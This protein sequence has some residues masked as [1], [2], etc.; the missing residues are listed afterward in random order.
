M[1][2]DELQKLVSTLKSEIDRAALIAQLQALI[3]AQRK[4]V[5]QPGLITVIIQSVSN[6]IADMTDTL[7]EAGSQL[8]D[9]SGLWRWF[10]H[11][12][13]DPDLRA[14]LLEAALH[15]AGVLACGL[16]GMVLA[17][18]LLRRV[19]GRVLARLPSN[20]GGKLG[21]AALTFVIQLVPLA[22]FAAASLL[23]MPFLLVRLNLHLNQVIVAAIY[24]V[25]VSGLLVALGRAVLQPTAPHLR[26]L[27]WSDPT[28]AYADRWLRRFVI[29]AVVGYMALETAVL[30]GLPRSGHAALQ[31][32]LGL[33]ISVLI[34]VVILQS[35]HRVAQW[36]RTT[37]RHGEAPAGT[38]RARL[39]NSWHL[40]AVFYVL[41]VFVVW[42][43]YPAAGLEFLVRATFLTGLAVA[44]GVALQTGLE[45]LLLRML[46]A[47]QAKRD[48]G[49]AAE[50]R[51]NRYLPVLFNLLRTAMAAIVLLVVL[52]IWGVNSFAVLFN[53]PGGRI[54]GGVLRIVTIVIGAM[55]VWELAVLALERYLQRITRAGRLA[56][57]RVKTMLP[58]GRNLLGIT[59]LVI[60]I[61]MLLSEV[62]V[63]I[64]PLLA[65]AGIVGLALGLGAQN[66]VKDLIGG[67]GLIME[68]AV[69]VGDVVKIGDNAGVVEKLTIRM[70][71]LRGL[72]GTVKFIPLGS[73]DVVQNMTKDFS[74]AVIDANVAYGA[75]VDEVVQALNDVGE[76]LAHDPAFESQIL[77]P[78]EMMGLDRFAD[79]A[80]VVRCRFKTKPASRWNVMR[81]FNR[82][83]K[84]VFD[85]RG[86]EIPFPHLTLT[87]SDTIQQL[88]A[89]RPAPPATAPPPPEAGTSP[90]PFAD[91]AD[92][93]APAKTQDES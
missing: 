62:G 53:E 39:A 44:I 34:V 43:L 4:V 71:R 70:I 73:V 28:A 37:R 83:M 14:R 93:A 24:A 38:S 85:A 19:S 68:D 72:D 33:A 76:D 77:A 10:N 69:A 11:A 84:A 54:V 22:A 87:M 5:E 36:L 75:K 12:S 20:W 31:R 45:R 13:N 3:D 81:E 52:G 86:I 23:A 79:S 17:Y 65:G 29:I 80:I 92:A 49:A 1:S 91:T 61:L 18:L 90:K 67:F 63:A 64:G 55:I 40:L 46:T 41:I 56:E 59:I 26:M 78:L 30:F 57:S 47:R 2:T 88:L 82:R 8:T 7:S 50:Q 25:V 6:G 42:L 9:F 15:I 51:A 60:A 16:A 32:L 35:R 58:V 21:G 74:Y 89:S 66:L 27:R 48:R